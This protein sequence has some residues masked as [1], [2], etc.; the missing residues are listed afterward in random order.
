MIPPGTSPK[1]LKR[2]VKYKTLVSKLKIAA[3][4][5]GLEYE[6]L[7]RYENKEAQKHNCT[8]FRLTNGRLP[9]FRIYIPRDKYLIYRMGV[10]TGHPYGYASHRIINKYLNFF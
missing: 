5:T 3:Y 7:Q 9:A 1:T 8:I 4:K 10:G 6:I 2:K